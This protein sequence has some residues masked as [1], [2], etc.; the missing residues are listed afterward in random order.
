MLLVVEVSSHVQWI[1]IS[2]RL[3]LIGQAPA[4]EGAGKV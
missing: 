2:F 4:V 3:F 1:N